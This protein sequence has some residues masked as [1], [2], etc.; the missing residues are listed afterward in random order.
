MFVDMRSD[1]STLFSSCCIFP[2]ARSAQDVELKHSQTED[3]LVLRKRHCT[4]HC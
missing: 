2:L 1:G 4:V 3:G